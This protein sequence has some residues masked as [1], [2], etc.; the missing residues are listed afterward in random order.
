M[1]AN[2]LRQLHAVHDRHDHVH[3]GHIKHLR[4][5]QRQRLGTA[6]HRGDLC[7]G[8]A[9][10]QLQLRHHQVHPVV[11]DHQDVQR[12]VGQVVI[13]QVF[14]ALVLCG[15]QRNLQPEQGAVP[16]L[17]DHANFSAMQADQFF[18]QGQ[19]QS[20]ATKG[21]VG[22]YIRV[23]KAAKNVLLTLKCDATPCIAHLQPQPFTLGDQL[24]V[25]RPFGRELDGVVY[26]VVQDLKQP[27]AV[28]MQSQRQCRIAMNVQVNPFAAGL[29]AMALLQLFRQGADFVVHRVQVQFARLQLRKIQNVVD[30]LQQMLG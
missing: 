3:Q 27:V 16:R 10:L 28:P 19:A 6:V 5:Q 11:I 8:P 13:L 1:L 22:L 2:V 30:H 21:A 17:T 25:Y 9:F 12:L 23:F 24:H 14:G 7:P 26:Q 29:L 18:T 20:R 4:I 15:L